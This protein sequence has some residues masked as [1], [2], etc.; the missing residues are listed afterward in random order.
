MCLEFHIIL[1]VVFDDLF[2]GVFPTVART[3]LELLE[4]LRGHAHDGVAEFA[5]EAD[6]ERA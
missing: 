2:V 3:V 6:V 4:I 1:Q 5:R